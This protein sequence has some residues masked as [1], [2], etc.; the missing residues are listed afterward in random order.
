MGNLFFPGL[1][2]TPV[3]QGL[4]KLRMGNVRLGVFR[5]AMFFFFA[6]PEL[7]LLVALICIAARHKW[8]K[9]QLKKGMEGYSAGVDSRNTGW[10]GDNHP[11]CRAFMQIL[12]KGCFAGARFTCQKNIAAGVLDKVVDELQFIV[13]G[14][15][16][17]PG[18]ARCYRF[19][20]I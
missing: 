18:H 11:L 17:F 6:E 1:A 10:S 20:L 4:K 14:G 3:L 7:A 12:E 13:C 5:G 16:S 19:L 2:E 8:A 9:G 15:H